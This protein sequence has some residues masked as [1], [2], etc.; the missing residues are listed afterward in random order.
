MIKKSKLREAI[1]PCVKIFKFF[2]FADVR[3]ERQSSVW[4]KLNALWILMKYVAM[5]GALGYLFCDSI[6]ARI[7]QLQRNAGRIPVVTIFFVGT[8]MKGFASL[9]Q[10]LFSSS[11]S[12]KFIERMEQVDDLLVNCLK[13]KINYGDLRWALL[14]NIIL[15]ILFYFVCCLGRI[16]TVTKL[17]PRAWRFIL[18]FYF[19][20]LFGQIFIQRFIFMVQLLT[21]Y[22]Q[23]IVHALEESINNQP[24]LVRA[25]EERKWNMRANHFKVKVMQKV[26]RLLWEASLLINDCFH[27]GLVVF[28]F[29]SFLSL[30]Y[31]GYSLC[32][33]ITKR[34]ANHLRQFLSI[35]MTFFGM[36][37]IHF[38]CQQ[39]TNSVIF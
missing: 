38:Y 18:H 5:T 1:D 3:V 20:I 35:F 12:L 36:F 8:M 14:G 21:F 7:S 23:I 10:S 27:F 19:P 26:Y 33:D 22:L 2:C 13:L 32:V 16:L 28:F 15:S 11:K 29:V 39:C 24:L 4:K 17:D 31:A 34:E 37:T 9:L 30:L 6:G 25:G